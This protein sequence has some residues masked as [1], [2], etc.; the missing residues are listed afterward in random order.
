MPHR[1]QRIQKRNRLTPPSTTRKLQHNFAQPNGTQRLGVGL[2]GGVHPVLDNEPFLVPGQEAGTDLVG[3]EEA[4]FFLEPHL[5]PA[6]GKMEDGG[7][8]E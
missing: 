7:A 5:V 8:K 1:L 6:E 3:L 4:D 2:A